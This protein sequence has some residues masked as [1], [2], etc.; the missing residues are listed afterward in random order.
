MP[1]NNREGNGE[2]TTEKHGHT[3]NSS[4]NFSL[5]VCS[6]LIFFYSSSSGIWMSGQGS[7]LKDLRLQ[8]K[9]H[10]LPRQRGPSSN[11]TSCVTSQTNLINPGQ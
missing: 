1:V 10:R 11:Y 6:C 3:H 4:P 8:L 7:S 2:E 9:Y 5:S